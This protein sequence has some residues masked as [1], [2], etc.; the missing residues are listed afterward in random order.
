[1][2][3]KRVV[4]KGVRIEAIL[5]TQGAWVVGGSNDEALCGDF[6]TA[7]TAISRYMRWIDEQEEDTEKEEIA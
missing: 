6:P 2:T 7:E 3:K 1:M 5:T 4:Y